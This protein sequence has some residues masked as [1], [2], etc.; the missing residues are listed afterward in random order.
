MLG[1]FSFYGEGIFGAG[2]AFY[3]CVCAFSSGVF[4]V[5][6]PFGGLSYGTESKSFSEK[7]QA[8]AMKKG[9]VDSSKR[10]DRNRAS[11]TGRMP[12]FYTA[13]MISTVFVRRHLA[14]VLSLVLLP[15]A[16]VGCGAKVV[17]YPEDHE[18]YLRI[19]K[20]VESLRQAY[21][22][23]DAAALAALMIPIDQLDRLQQEAESDFEIYPHISLEFR[24]ER[25]M[26]EGEDVDVYVHWQGLWKKHPDDPGLRQRGH[27]RFQ[28]VGT[29]AILLRG[30]QGDAPFGMKGRQDLADSPVSPKR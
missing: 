17:Q 16:M 28:W 8:S 2:A 9:P 11:L 6:W 30:V 15:F 20:A 10:S 1:E 13:D 26:I 18:R 21:I 25:I 3:I 5:R 22:K 12:H 7:L 14:V 29:K 19:D 24:V 23:K 4:S 27:S